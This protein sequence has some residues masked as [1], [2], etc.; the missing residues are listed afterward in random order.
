MSLYRGVLWF[1][2]SGTRYWWAFPSNCEHELIAVWKSQFPAYRDVRWVFLA[3]GTANCTGTVYRTCDGWDSETGT[4]K[5]EKCD[6]EPFD[7]LDTDYCHTCHET[8]P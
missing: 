1:D 2:R 4:I 7:E 3:T 6:R 8:L 5:G